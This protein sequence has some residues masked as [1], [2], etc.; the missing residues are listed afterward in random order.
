MSGRGVSEADSFRASELYPPLPFLLFLS[1]WS[2]TCTTIPRVLDLPTMKSITDPSILLQ[3]TLY[4]LLD[5]AQPRHLCFDLSLTR[6]TLHRP[7][8]LLR[9]P[10]LLALFNPPS[11][12]QKLFDP[13]LST[14]SSPCSLCWRPWLAGRA[15]HLVDPHPISPATKAARIQPPSPRRSS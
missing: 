4:C 8:H 14:S 15:V 9:W 13:Y 6:L 7:L 12:L 5:S 2:T 1:S 10:R 3:A 11:N